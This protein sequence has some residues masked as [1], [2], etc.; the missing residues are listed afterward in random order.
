[1]WLHLAITQLS[2]NTKTNTNEC[3]KCTFFRKNVLDK[4]F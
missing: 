2:H 3:S 4:E 1:M